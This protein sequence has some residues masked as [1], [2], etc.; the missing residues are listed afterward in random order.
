MIDRIAAALVARM[1]ELRDAESERGD[2]PVS[3]AIIIAGLAVLAAAV[4][5]WAVA[6]ANHFMSTAP[7]GN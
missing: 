3:T 4:V 2:S 5:A 1:S 7:G 6:R